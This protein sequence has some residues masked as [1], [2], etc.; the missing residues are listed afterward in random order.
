[1]SKEY[2]ERKA[3]EKQRQSAKKST[4]A[5]KPASTKKSAGVGGAIAKGIRTVSKQVQSTQQKA[6]DQILGEDVVNVV[7]GAARK[8]ALDSY[9]SAYGNLGGYDPNGAMTFGQAQSYLAALENARAATKSGVS[10]RAFLPKTPKELNDF[11]G[12]YKALGGEADRIRAALAKGEKAYNA[13]YYYPRKYNGSDAAKINQAMAKLRFDGDAGKDELAWLKENQYN[14]WTSDQIKKGI[15]DTQRQIE[16]Q[17]KRK[18]NNLILEDRLKRM[19]DAAY[20]VTT[21]DWSAQDLK[22]MARYASIY[23]KRDNADLAEAFAQ[24]GASAQ[25]RSYEKEL[26]S[27]YKKFKGMGYSDEEISALRTY[28]LQNQHAMERARDLRELSEFS[29]DHKVLASI[30]SVPMNMMSGIGY[31]DLARQK[32]T[33]GTDP[34]TGAKKRVDQYAPLTAMSDAATTMRGAVSE[35]MSGLGRFLYNTGMS[36]VDSRM[37]M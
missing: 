23:E 16:E 12:N 19:Q 7:E 2:A 25:A 21:R 10:A 37:A 35:D 34:I 20:T 4:S 31:A 6:Y 32:L 8:S 9:I 24:S 27:L 13:E 36:I 14:Y 30:A 26:G 17:K 3:K 29:K 33:A 28:F 11:L 1:M 18:R 5:T 15:A 22:D